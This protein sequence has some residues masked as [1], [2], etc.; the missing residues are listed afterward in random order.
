MSFV[1]KA[2]NRLK[3]QETP[4]EPV[5]PSGT[6]GFEVRWMRILH[7]ARKRGAR[8]G[9]PAGGESR[10]AGPAGRPAGRVTSTG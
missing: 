4:A 10:S 9:R 5:R 3:Q 1:E 7:T 8:A 6:L 2:L